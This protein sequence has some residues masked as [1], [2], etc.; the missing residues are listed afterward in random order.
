M[1]EIV[2]RRAGAAGRITLNRPAALNALTPAMCSEIARALDAWADED[3][4]GMVIVDAAP[5]RA[6]CAGG[7]IAMIYQAGLARDHD[8]P[9]GFWR[10]EYRMN[11]RIATYPKPIASFLHGFT[12]GGGVGVGCHAS[13]RIVGETSRIAMPECGIGLI[14]DVGG[15]L[16]LARAPG[17]LG[18][19]LG[20]TGHRMNPAD[21]IHA[22]FADYYLPEAAWPDLIA[23]LERG[24]DWAAIESAATDPGDSALARRQDAIDPIFRHETLAEIAGA[25]ERD[26]SDFANETLSALRCVSPLSAACALV[27]IRKAR[28]ADDIEAA[29]ELEYRFTHRA[30]SDGEL[31]EGIRAQ[32]IDKDRRPRW[33]HS[34]PADVPD[35][36][37][38]AMTAPLNAQGWTLEKTE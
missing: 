12:M 7:D 23:R 2:I 32:V 27:T 22:G 17:H 10:D 16:L 29:L 37:V 21:A 4:I 19:Y 26:G 34:G 24:A 33:R 3:D 25:L 11:A 36:E 18:E 15:S 31:M 13:H 5:G 20:T 6:F 28:A 30:L 35:A 1:T 9:R 38:A 14:P 8:G